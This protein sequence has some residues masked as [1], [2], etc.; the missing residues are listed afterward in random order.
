[1]FATCPST[2]QQMRCMTSSAS[3]A[4]SGK[5]GCKCTLSQSSIPC[6]LSAKPCLYAFAGCRGAAK[7]TRGTAYVVYEDIYDAKTAVDHLS[8]FNVANRYLIVLYYNTT[9]HSKKVCAMFLL[10]SGWACGCIVCDSLQTS[11][12]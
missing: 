3:S 1:M 7:D 6:S 2:S 4:A 9:K 11:C 12:R 5:Y 10:L 8:G